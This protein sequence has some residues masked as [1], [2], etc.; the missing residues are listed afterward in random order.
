MF[1]KGINPLW[2]ALGLV[3]LLI[4]WLASG[5]V[6][7]SADEAPDVTEEVVESPSRIEAELYEAE[8]Y[9]PELGVQGRIEPW[10]QIQII[11]RVSG[12]VI[13]L[14]VAQGESVESGSVLLQLDAEERAARVA[15]L[16]ADAELAA[17]ELSG[18]EQLR[19]QDLASQIE[20]LRLVAERARVATELEAAEMALSY[21]RPE[22][23]FS[24][25]FDRRLIELGDYVQSGQ[26][27]VHFTDISRLRIM[28]QIPQQEVARLNVGQPVEVQL[29]DDSVLRGELRHIATV[30]DPETR[31]F[32]VE[33][34]AENP[35]L[36][37]IAGGTASLKIQLAEVFAHQ[38][39]P[40]LLSLDGDGRLVVRYVDEDERVREQEVRLLS[41]GRDSA[42]VE[43]L[44]EQVRL[45][46][47][48]AGFV[49]LGQQV[50]VVMAEED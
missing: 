13:D 40:S 3:L 50:E 14:P 41:A 26:E 22:A 8:Y 45:I 36:R 7:R 21:T 48:G 30:A 23:P 2:L 4:I 16:E 19:R 15:Q 31:S 24:G 32:F 38:L 37:R 17:A 28:A 46:T 5:D 29:L 6:L 42:W 10:R 43:G 27:L 11:A 18:A 39:S 34:E 47:Q 9:Q 35:D 44:P 33:V 49:E 20:Y 12:E 25:I 1:L